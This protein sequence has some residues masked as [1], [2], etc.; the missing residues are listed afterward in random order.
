MSF[1]SGLGKGLYRAFDGTNLAVTQAILAGDYQSAAAIRARQTEL[2]RQLQ[3]EGDEKGFDP[4]AGWAGTKGS[5]DGSVPPGGAASSPPP[6]DIGPQ[7]APPPGMPAPGISAALA[8]AHFQGPSDLVA[9]AVADG[10]GSR[11]GAFPGTRW[12]LSG[13]LGNIPHIQTHAQATSLPRGACFF[14][15]DFSLRRNV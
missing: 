14:A 15:P 13:A 2:E 10:R 11:A 9:G 1:L 7:F 8:S 12:A 6:G 4:D 5:L 3:Q